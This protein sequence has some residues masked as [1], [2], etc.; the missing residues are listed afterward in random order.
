MRR[1]FRLPAAHFFGSWTLQL[2]LIACV[3]I[4]GQRVNPVKA[5]IATVLAPVLI[6]V[7]LL[8]IGP[9]NPAI[10]YAVYWTLY[11]TVLAGFYLLLRWR[12]SRR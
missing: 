8:R 4:A 7:V 5:A 9:R 1:L 10:G 3:L 6:P 2:I 12:A 11:L